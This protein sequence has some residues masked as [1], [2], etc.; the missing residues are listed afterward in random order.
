MNKHFVERK[1]ESWKP[2]KNS[3]GLKLQIAT[4]EIRRDWEVS[5]IRLGKI[6]KCFNFQL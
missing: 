5:M 2:D 4:A 1:N 3:L 6:E